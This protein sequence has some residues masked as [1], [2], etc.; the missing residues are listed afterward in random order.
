MAGNA[1]L[2]AAFVA[3]C[4]PFDG[5]FRAQIYGRWAPSVL[6]AG[7]PVLPELAEPGGAV[8]ALASPV[9]VRAPPLPP[10]RPPRA[11]SSD[12]MS[13]SPGQGAFVFGA[14]ARAVRTTEAG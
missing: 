4:G 6:A 12:R 14:P 5:A 11:L 10:P 13:W 3:Y 7:I 9:Q 8:R 2:A 1:L